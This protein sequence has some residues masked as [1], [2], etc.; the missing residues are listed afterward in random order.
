MDG[1]HVSM[2]TG[3]GTSRESMVIFSW[4]WTGIAAIVTIFSAVGYVGDVRGGNATATV[5]HVYMQEAY[6]VSFLTNDGRLCLADHKWEPRPDRVN[7]GDTFQVHY[8][9]FGPCDNFHRA[10]DRAYPSVY[11]TGPVALAGGILALLLLRE[12]IADGRYSGPPRF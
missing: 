5:V 2:F 8:S 9:R 3:P 4:L 7:V 11:A 10:D 1:Y 6:S 12:R